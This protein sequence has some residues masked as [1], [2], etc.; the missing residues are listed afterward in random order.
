LKD[1]W[2]LTIPIIALIAFLAMGLPVSFAAIY[3]IGTT[4]IVSWFR[5]HTRMRFKDILD[6]L[7]D[8]TRQA[9]STIIVCGVVGI[10]IGVVNLTSFG[11]TL[12]AAI[13]QLGAGSLFFTLF[14]T[15][16]ASIIL[17]MGLPSIPA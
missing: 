13:T 16:L 11:A 12:T 8:G 7:A 17:G 3:T 10:I 5:K 14:L 9:L 1:G 15:M 6:A 4:V 2:H